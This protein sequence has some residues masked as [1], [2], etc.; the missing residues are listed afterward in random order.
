MFFLKKKKKS[1][2]NFA[3]FLSLISLQLKMALLKEYKEQSQTA[4][5]YEYL[6]QLED[7]TTCTYFFSKV[8]IVTDFFYFILFFCIKSLLNQ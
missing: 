7:N 6:V 4:S 8:I 5:F 2:T 1:N 3:F